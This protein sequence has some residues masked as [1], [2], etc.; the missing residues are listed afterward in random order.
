M[1]AKQS[2]PPIERAACL[3]NLQ[4]VVPADDEAAKRFP[5][6]YDCLMPRWKEG[7]CVRQSGK[8]SIRITG[9]LFTIT[10]ECPTEGLQA[11]LSSET[12][13]DLFTRLEKLLAS[14]KAQWVPSWEI[15]KKARQARVK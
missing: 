14:G 7:A 10:L 1:E 11:S 3:E 8:I 5:T 2:K 9:S 4:V 15:Q 6:I 12:F 13:A